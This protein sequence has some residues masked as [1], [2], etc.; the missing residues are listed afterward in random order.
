MEGK[1]RMRKGTELDRSGNRQ[2]NKERKKRRLRQLLYLKNK[3]MQK[4]NKLFLFC[5]LIA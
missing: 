2:R 3:H 5:L 1:E 4:V